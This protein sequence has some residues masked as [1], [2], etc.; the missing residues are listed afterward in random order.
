MKDKAFTLIEMILVVSM[1]GVLSVIGITSYD[2]SKNKALARE[3]VANLKLIA[4]AEKIYR[5][6]SDS[7]T[8]VACDDA[9]ECN[10]TL[11]LNLNETNWAYSVAL[12]GSDASM[13]AT[14]VSDTGCSYTLSTSSDSEP[15][16][17]DCPAGMN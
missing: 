9:A 5:M 13:Q 2:K 1:V 10:S 14:L 8:Y 16:P 7:N 15:A 4:A 17:N 12:D 6:E 3:A 11:N